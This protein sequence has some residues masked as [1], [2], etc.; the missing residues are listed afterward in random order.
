MQSLEH[1][2]RAGLGL[3]YH[4]HPIPLFSLMA[5]LHGGNV[6]RIGG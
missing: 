5:V 2:S 1:F 3:L 4:P 6:T